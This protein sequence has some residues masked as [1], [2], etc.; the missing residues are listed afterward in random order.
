MF[1]AAYGIIA[2]R[3]LDFEIYMK[4]QLNIIYKNKKG[5]QKKHITQGCKKVLSKEHKIQTLQ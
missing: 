5:I 1:M 3:L 4:A 2:S